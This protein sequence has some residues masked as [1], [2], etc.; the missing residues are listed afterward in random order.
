M[1][2]LIMD[3][4]LTITS[5]MQHAEINHPDAEI[6]SV[7]HDNPRHRYT[8]A[9]AFLRTRK[10]ANALIQYGILEGDRIATLAWN[11]YRHFE[12]YYAVSGIAA[13]T[14]TINPRLFAEQII[15]II[16]HAEDRLIFVDPMIVPIIEP[17]QKELANVESFIILTDEANMPS[18]SLANSQCYETFIADA[19]AEIEWPLFDENTAS[20]L[21]YTSG[22]T[23][24]PKGVLYSHRANVLHSYSSTSPEVFNFAVGD[25]AMPV[26][27]MFHVNAWGIPYA[28]PM[29]GAKLVFPGP[30]M[31]DGETLQ[32]LIEEEGV[33][34]SAGVPTVWLALLEYL[35]SSGKKIESLNRVIIGGSAC[36]ESIMREFQDKHGVYVNHAWGMTETSPLGTV[37]TLKPEMKTLSEAEQYKIRLKQGRTLFGIQMKIVDDDNNELPRDGIASG[38]LKVRGPWVCSDYYKLDEPSD[39]HDEEG[40]FATGDVATIDAE[41]YMQITDRSKDVIK[42]GGEWIS[43]IDLENIAVGHPKLAEA[44]VIGIAHPKWTERPLLI[45][46]LKEAE[47][48]SKEELLS[49]LEDKVARWWLPDDVIFVEEIPHTATGKILKLELR[50]QFEN[51]SFPLDK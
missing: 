18:T 4:P 7:T 25:V 20:S 34:F 36:P 22:T 16:N 39:V 15:Y 47:S 24:N 26:V 11:D 2:G 50:K 40:W 12:L 1:Q 21:C 49:W 29:M 37:N 14:H 46:I 27:P 32:A 6:V 28:A 35:N 31:G 42:S 13:V 17:L 10:L 5:I 48:L 23:G 19:S 8:Y 41:G 38:L 33:T 45:A 51:Y 9:E 43:S 30:K 44:A 3:Y